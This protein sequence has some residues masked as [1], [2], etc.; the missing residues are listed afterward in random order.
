MR[1]DEAGTAGDEIALHRDPRALEEHGAGRS[2]RRRPGPLSEPDYVLAAESLES[3]PGVEN[4]RR[5]LDHVPVV[6]RSVRSDDDRAIGSAEERLGEPGPGHRLL[7]AM[8]EL[9]LLH[10]RIV[11]GDLGAAGPQQL[12]DIYGGRLRVSSMSA[13]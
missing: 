5:V 12:V 3:V 2:R 9:E 4:E 13:L 11:E 6:E 1:A 10:E 8:A 7:A